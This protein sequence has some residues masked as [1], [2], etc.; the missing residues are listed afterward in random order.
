MLEYAA[1]PLAAWAL[2]AMMS[3]ARTA[4]RRGDDGRRVRPWRWIAAHPWRTAH[5]ALGSLLGLALLDAGGLLAT[6]PAAGL[7][8]AGV[9]L[10]G[11]EI[12]DAVQRIAPQ[13]ARAALERLGAGGGGQGGW[14]EP[15]ALAALALVFVGIL[16]GW[17]DP[18]LAWWLGAALGVGLPAG[19]VVVVVRHD[20]WRELWPSRTLDRYAAL[21]TYGTIALWWA[22]LGLAA[23][24]IWGPG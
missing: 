19:L 20:G 13:A 11:V 24:G 10:A 3:Y 2:G 14:M 9:G 23:L 6:Q 4:A 17:A 22:V 18:A 1:H 15:R 7:L 12:A 5:A 8:A 16:A 21:V